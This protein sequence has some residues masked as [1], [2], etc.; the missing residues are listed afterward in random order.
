MENRKVGHNCA[1][2]VPVYCLRFPFGFCCI[3]DSRFIFIRVAT[4]KTPVVVK[5]L[6]KKKGNVELLFYFLAS[7]NLLTSLS[8]TGVAAF[9]L[10]IA[11]SLELGSTLF[12]APHPSAVWTEYSVFGCCDY[13]LV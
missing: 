12:L 1:Y 5:K 11:F 8:R 9:H 13:T 2:Q 4:L 6:G 3:L 10:G 7:V